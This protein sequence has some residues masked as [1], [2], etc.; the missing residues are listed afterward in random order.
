MKFTSFSKVHK[1]VPPEFVRKLPFRLR[2]NFLPWL[3]PFSKVLQG[4]LILLLHI[5]HKGNHD[6]SL[7]LYFL[8]ESQN[9]S[10]KLLEKISTSTLLAP[11]PSTC[12]IGLLDGF[13]YYRNGEFIKFSICITRDETLPS[14]AASAA[15]DHESG[16][17]TLVL[18]LI[19]YGIL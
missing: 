15:S 10:L 7:A 5:F 9:N 16:D 13:P 1:M 11:L 17:S 19:F 8:H 6:H 4:G 3:P 14:C 18:L 12:S 2:R